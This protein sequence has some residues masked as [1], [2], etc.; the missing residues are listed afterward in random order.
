MNTDANFALFSGLTAEVRTEQLAKRLTVLK[1][2]IDQGLFEAWPH[3]SHDSPQDAT[4]VHYVSDKLLLVNGS[5][6]KL[7]SRQNGEFPMDRPI[8][9]TLYPDSPSADVRLDISL[10]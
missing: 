1:E 5:E 7:L 3:K 8:G 6:L 9:F 2:L 4:E 10:A